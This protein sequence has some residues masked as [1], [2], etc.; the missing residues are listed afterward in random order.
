MCRK[1][2][3][4]TGGCPAGAPRTCGMTEREKYSA[5]P[6]RAR[7]TFT[8]SELCSSSAERIGAA[9]VAMSQ[10]AASS[11][12][13]AT[14]SIRAG[15]IRG[16]S[17]CTLTTTS[18]ARPRMASAIRSVPDGWSGLVIATA[19]P[20]D[21]AAA[22]MRASSVATRI[23]ARRRACRARCTTQAS[24]GLPPTG[25]RLLPGNRVEPQR[26]GMTPIA[27][28]PI[29]S[30]LSCGS[31]VLPACTPPCPACPRR[32]PRR[33]SPAPSPRGNPRPPPAPS[34]RPR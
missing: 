20:K 25:A 21:S 24:S 29:S 32:R 18:A 4:G 6:S 30:R 31:A 17:P 19:T 2:S 10:S 28:A 9:A 33:D 12:V 8:T 26:D 13:P 3:P 1:C 34:R 23:S 11:S 5:R 22:A 14:R 16:S 7:T 15:S 27:R